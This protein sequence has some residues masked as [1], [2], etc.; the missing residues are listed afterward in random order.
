MNVVLILGRDMVVEVH[1][2][3]I[4]GSLIDLKEDVEEE[5]V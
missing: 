5:K 4:M 1:S 3:D 2:A